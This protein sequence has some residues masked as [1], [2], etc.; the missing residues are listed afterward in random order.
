MPLSLSRLDWWVAENGN[1]MN[2]VG[3]VPGH[4]IFR[5]FSG[6]SIEDGNAVR[7]VNSLEIC[8]FDVQILVHQD[9]IRPQATVKDRVLV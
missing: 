4:V 6:K 8:N 5:A 9:V 2:K 1:G 3:I 7:L